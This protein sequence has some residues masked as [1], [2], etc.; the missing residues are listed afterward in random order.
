ML[1]DLESNH[2]NSF[3]PTNRFNQFRITARGIIIEN[4]QILFVSD[5]GKYWYTPG[6]RLEPDESMEACVEREIFEE[7]GL[8][9]KAG[10]LLFVQECLDIKDSTHK[11]HFY[12]LTSVQTGTVSEHWFDTGGSVKYRQFF[13][14][15]DIKNDTHIVPRFLMALEWDEAFTVQENLSRHL[16]SNGS[17]TFY[18]GCIFTRG[19]EMIGKNAGRNQKATDGALEM[20]EAEE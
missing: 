1:T 14:P 10:P 2:A 13:S 5:E 17:Q 15:S 11:I 20:V 19:F 9:V 7:T 6:G 16:N 4:E 3:N 18:R 8:V 12:F